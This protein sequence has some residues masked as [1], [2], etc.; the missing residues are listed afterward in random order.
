MLTRLLHACGLELGPE[1]EMMPAQGDNPDG[2]WEN[3]RFV[4]IN[5]EIL[6]ELGGA[7]DVP[8]V[9]DFTSDRL[10]PLRAK[11]ELLIGDF[12]AA[13]H[14][15]WKDPRSSLTLPF[16]QEL[17]P[18]LK[19]VIMVRNPLEVA[20]SLRERN[21][22]S[23]AFGLRLWEVY[24]RFL[25]EATHPTQRIV[26]RYDLFFEDP[27][28]ELQRITAFIGLPSSQI[29]NAAA[30][31]SKKRRHTQFTVEQMIDARVASEVVNLYRELTTEADGGAVETHDVRSVELSATELLP[32]SISRLRGSDIRITELVAHLQKQ[33]EARNNLEEKFRHSAA[34]AARLEE[35]L[36]GMRARLDAADGEVQQLRERLVE[37]NHLLHGRS[38]SLAESEA[39]VVELTNNLR[40]QL[41]ATRKLSRLLDDLD[42]AAAR[43]RSSRRWKIANP[44]AALKAMLFPKRRL[45]GY[46]HLEKIVSAYAKWRSDH[47]EVDKVD[48][49]IHALESGA[50]SAVSANGES[51][52]R[53]EPRALTQP[54]AFAVHEHVEVSII[55]PVFNKFRFTHAC[56]AA[57]QRHVEGECF[58]VIVVDDGS[59]DAD[60]GDDRANS[61]HH[62]CA[63]RDEFRIHR[64]MQ[65]RR[66]KGAGRL[67][68]FLE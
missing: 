20:Y 38:I 14:W 4:A 13:A 63:Q 62:L 55:I 40:R 66:R 34:T 56:L 31:V 57:L 1:S 39:R 26:T 43:L 35:R 11:A 19:V 50:N 29:D 51:A 22:T 18:A 65:S 8:P 64:F 9:R 33:D 59:T 24:N 25:V 42:S 23:Y 54:I 44:V 7:W 16:W 15:G 37:T 27:L 67:P 28:K 52:T 32:G 3:L 48:D 30:L 12:R 36:E 68:G 46:G 6:N 5:D 10:N 60:A 53:L 61:R 47:S 17:L 58:E 21:G 45:L 2:F 41:K 49:A